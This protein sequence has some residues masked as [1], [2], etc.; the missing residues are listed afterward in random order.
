MTWSMTQVTVDDPDKMDSYEVK[1]DG[2]IYVG[3]DFAGCTVEAT[4]KV[5]DDAETPLSEASDE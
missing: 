2:R 5:K 4:L 1:D 3:K